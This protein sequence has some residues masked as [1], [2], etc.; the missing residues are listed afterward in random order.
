[1]LLVIHIR[2]YLSGQITIFAFPNWYDVS[3]LRLRHHDIDLDALAL[4]DSA[5]NFD[6]PPLP[7]VQDLIIGNGAA[8]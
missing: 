4:R 6:P 8:N 3:F 1:M 7:F 2:I 5:R